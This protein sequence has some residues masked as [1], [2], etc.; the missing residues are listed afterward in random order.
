MGTCSWS[1]ED[2]RD[3]FYPDGLASG[4]ELPYYATYLP[5]VEVDATFYSAPRPEVA[6]GW[7]GKTP[8]R[9]EFT[10]KMPRQITHDARLRD[11]GAETAAFIESLQPLG[12]KL[13]AVLVQLPPTFRPQS[14][15]DA[16]RG[17][18]DALPTGEDAPRFAVEFRHA[19]WRRPRFIRLLEEHRVA[20]VWNDGTAAS[21]GAAAPFAVLPQTTDLLY[22]RLLGDVATKFR[23]DGERHFRYGSLLWPRDQALEGWARRIE[24]H[25]EDCER[26]FVMIDNH[27]EGFSPLT[28]QRLAR[29]LGI[30][31]E[32]P[33]LV[34]HAP[35]AG[36]LPAERD[37]QMPLL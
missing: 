32:L 34:A 10:A 2:W 16:L 1:F 35:V 24:R 17:F 3:V 28:C 11:C 33:S 8:D 13:G 6:A 26:I 12:A 23:P 31:I 25:L 22:L 29:L 5:A 20:W 30:A 9:F 7:A 37:E 36:D 18:L 4:Q 27:F 19:D 14:D 21:D 15:E